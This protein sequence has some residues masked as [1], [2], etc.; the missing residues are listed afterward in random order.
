EKEKKYPKKMYEGIQK[1]SGK[2]KFTKFMHKLIFKPVQSTRTL[3]RKKEVIKNEDFTRFQGK[4]LRNINIT[5]LDP[6]GYSERDEKRKP[7]YWSERTGNNLHVKSK[8]FA[9]RNFLLIKK[10]EP[11][12]SLLVRESERLIRSQRFVR[13]VKIT[14]V[15]AGADSVDV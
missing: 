12:D 7:K 5:T 10:N 15:M 4:I 2:S 3:Q 9:I 6:F 11:L 1:Y 13:S 8:Y 14:P